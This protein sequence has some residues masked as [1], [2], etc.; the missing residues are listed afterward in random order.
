MRGQLRTIADALDHSIPDPEIMD[1]LVVAG[2]PST[3]SDFDLGAT[4]LS[5]LTSE[6]ASTEFMFEKGVLQTVFIFTQPD[7]EH[8]AYPEPDALIEGLSGTATR[9]EVRAMF[10]EPEWSV[11]V[12]DRFHVED[13]LFIR[14]G[15]RDDRTTKITVMSHIPVL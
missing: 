14:F 9:D 8:G 15:Y 7:D 13:R 3:R 6:D 11:A 4:K 12:A 5:Y 2:L 10:G 1:A